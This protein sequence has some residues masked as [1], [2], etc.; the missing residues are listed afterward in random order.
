VPLEELY[1]L[2]IAFPERARDRP[3]AMS[4]GVFHVRALPN[5]KLCELDVVF[6]TRNY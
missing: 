5:E 4:L 3:V 2:R 1:D 6:L